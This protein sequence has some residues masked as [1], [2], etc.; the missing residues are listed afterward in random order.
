MIIPSCAIVSS[1]CFQHQPDD[2]I[3]YISGAAHEKSETLIQIHDGSL[4]N[5]K[6]MHCKNR[7][8]HSNKMQRVRRQK[9]EKGISVS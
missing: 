8:E 9:P 7:K 5:T 1:V 4:F 2:W 6:S 3:V